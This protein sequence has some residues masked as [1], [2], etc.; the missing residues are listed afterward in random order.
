[1]RGIFYAANSGASPAHPNLAA[2]TCAERPDLSEAFS[3]AGSLT[4]ARRHGEVIPS[5]PAGNILAVQGDPSR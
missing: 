1:M 2:L 3:T 5:T 4:V